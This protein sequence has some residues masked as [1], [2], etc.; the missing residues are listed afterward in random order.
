MPEMGT[1]PDMPMPCRP[2]GPMCRMELPMGHWPSTE[3]EFSQRM[4][5]GL[6]LPFFSLRCGW[7]RTVFATVL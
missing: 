4:I 1:V 2:E 5:W 7:P 6:N 3:G